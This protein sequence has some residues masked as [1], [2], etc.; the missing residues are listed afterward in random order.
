[1][2]KAELRKRVD[3][4]KAEIDSLKSTVDKIKEHVSGL[5]DKPTSDK[6]VSFVNAVKGLV[7][8]AKQEAKNEL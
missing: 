2:D 7:S 1:M 4:R 6:N 3:A 5:G 8:E